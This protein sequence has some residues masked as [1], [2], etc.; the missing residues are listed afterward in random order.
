MLLWKDSLYFSGK[1][2]I[3]SKSNYKILTRD[4]ICDFERY[5]WWNKKEF[6]LLSWTVK[7]DYLHKNGDTFY[8]R[9]EVFSVCPNFDKFGKPCKM[10]DGNL[11]SGTDKCTFYHNFGEELRFIK[12]KY[13]DG[14]IVL[15]YQ[16]LR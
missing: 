3:K 9:L 1:R 11:Y 14:D 12:N 13:D 2:T 4:S 7:I 10:P 16:E 6:G 8:V 5:L 15:Y